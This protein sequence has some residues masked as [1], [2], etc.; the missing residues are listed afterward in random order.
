M[1][2]SKPH[3]PSSHRRIPERC[4]EANRKHWV[5]IRVTGSDSVS[6][7]C[8][9]RNKHHLMLLTGSYTL[10]IKTHLPAVCLFHDNRALPM[11]VS[12]LLSF[13]IWNHKGPSMRGQSI[14]TRT[15]YSAFWSVVVFEIVSV[16]SKEKLPWRR[17]GTTL[18]WAWEQIFRM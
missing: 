6:S 12:Q 3:N 17:V 5:L 18:A 4:V 8:L 13:V 15:Y 14:G 1:W 2:N 9:D 10:S 11:R 7:P 16:C